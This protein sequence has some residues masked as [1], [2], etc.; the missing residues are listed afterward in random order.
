MVP[1]VIVSLAKMPLTA[2]GK[3]DRK[4]LPAPE[5][6]GRVWR[7]PRTAQEEILCGL[8][9]EVLGVGRVGLDDNFFELG[10]HSLLAMALIGKIRTAFGV[11]VSIQ[12]V[13]ESSTV[14]GLAERLHQAQNARAAVCR[15]DR[16]REIPLSF[17]Q[18]RLWFL[19]RMDP[20]S[21]AYNI[22]LAL[23]LSGALDYAALEA[24][25]GDV[26]ERH[27]SLRTIFRETDGVPRQH[28]LARQ[29]TRFRMTI[30]SSSEAALR[31]HM[32]E[33]VARGFDLTSD[34]P[35]RADLLVLNSEEHVLLLI[36]HHIAADGSSLRPLGRDLAQAYGA[37]R[38]GVAPPWGALAVQY[39]DYTL[40]QRELLGAASDPESLMA[41]QLGYWKE[42]LKDLPEEIPLP[43]DR[44]R[45]AVAS[46]RGGAEFLRVPAA[47]HEK[48][49]AL[50]QGEQASLFMVLQAG[51]ATLLMR[52]GSGSDI[53]IGSAIAGRTDSALEDLVGF[54]VNTLVLRT[55]VSGNPTFRQLL[56]RVR[57]SDLNAYA[58]QDLPFE[59]LVE[60]LNPTRSLARQP[61][62]QVML[63]L[64]TTTGEEGFV[65]PG[66]RVAMETAGIKAS[67]FDLWLNL[68]EKRSAGGT[69]EGLEGWIEYAYDLFDR[70]TVE[71]F[72]ERLVRLLEG[73]ASEP[74][75]PIGN[76][77]LLEER[78]RECLLREWNGE[79]RPLPGECLAVL[80][81]AQVDRRGEAVAVACEGEW[82][83]YAELNR[84]ANQLARLL[85][86]AGVGAED[87]VAVALPRSLDLIVS[88]VAIVKA[89]A[90]YLPLDVELPEERLT[91]Q[92]NDARV[93][94]V[95]T[96]G[97][98]R[99]RLGMVAA[100]VW[101]LDTKSARLAEQSDE[102]LGRASEVKNLAYVMY[103][104]GSTG[105]PKGILV[106]QEGIQ[107]LVLNS[108]Y[109][110][111]GPED[112]VAQAAN[113][114]FDAATFEIW[115][116]LL[117]GARLEVIDRET[118]L[119][120]AALADKLASAGVTVAFLTTA[121]F[122]Q[123]V[124]QQPGA[125]SGLEYLLFGGEMADGK[126]VGK[127]AREAGP[128]YLLHKYGPTET[129]TFATSFAVPRE[130][131]ANSIP[132]G[133]AIANTE[134]YVLDGNLELAPVGVAG[135]LYIAGPGLGR[136]YLQRPGLTSERFVANPL[137][138]AAS[139]MYRTGDLV[140]WRAD[141]Q[142]EF[143]G[144]LDGQVKIRGFRVELGEI[145]AALQRLENVA[146][147]AVVLGEDASGEKRLVGY[148][149]A[150]A[151]QSVEASQLRRQLGRTLPEYMVPSALAVLERLPL[152]GNGK[153]DRRALPMPEVE[154]ASRRAPE[155]R[156][157]EILCGLFGE[158]L[159]VDEVSADDN[160]FE[161]GGHSLSATRLISRIR[162]TFGVEVT[163]RTLF[164]TPTVGEFAQTLEDLILEDLASVSETEAMEI[165]AAP[166]FAASN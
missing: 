151:G 5:Y 4:A 70:D 119:N 66:A 60:E 123:V 117:H 31:R 156:V 83:S 20:G 118:L 50:A 54:F 99:A 63:S 90:A 158:V 162:T 128:R 69:P 144:R 91:F 71:R 145:E 160:F 124:D 155:T 102:N 112:C 16:P 127:L 6:E 106:T 109:V 65:L 64:Q 129:T 154:H 62:F 33:A 132:I 111:L 26:L 148:V 88:I 17:A 163:I 114:S 34:I 39:A 48:L 32:T 150:A 67:R 137:G 57:T 51:L 116:A 97:A 40:W 43:V 93:R 29:E 138:A 103:T 143:L 126:R 3:V 36:V 45:P 130:W 76:I 136:G 61:L 55:D 94:L 81:E 10:G 104:S 131:E 35:L 47:L 77:S 120:P 92:L 41:R 85:V 141:G 89:G 134:V 125:F 8:F 19:N 37:R 9:S 21:P 96:H 52:Y 78:E 30:T 166:A 15:V 42:A 53:P 142:L 165:V 11:E 7:G 159:G 72:A 105:I 146:Q 14:E 49:L 140:K 86:S 18:R 147:A 44:P 110:Q 139:R 2:N 113:C 46:Y 73:A 122:H 149:V 1:S 80:F 161:L 24:A 25:L 84:R 108:G 79:A 121:L 27:E 82:L 101:E 59:R 58:H 22:P 107:R 152:N 23:R 75:R 153:L 28:I 13:F 100:E 133:R 56:G 115:G 157:E 38:R 74:D 95:L 68:R 98:L 135:E 164:E 12:Q 87:V